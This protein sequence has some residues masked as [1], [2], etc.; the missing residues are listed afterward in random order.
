MRKM[1]WRSLSFCSLSSENTE[2]MEKNSEKKPNLRLQSTS[3]EV[4]CVFAL[5]EGRPLLQ[6]VVLQQLQHVSGP[7]LFPRLLRFH[8]VHEPSVRVG[9]LG[10]DEILRLSSCA[11]Q[12]AGKHKLLAAGEERRA[13]MNYRLYP[14]I[15][16]KLGCES[17]HN[18]ILIC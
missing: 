12:T 6:G 13:S 3:N 2:A 7:K 17:P 8:N 16:T 18:P 4:L 14:L 15:M 10:R 11:E 5:S 1:S 9:W